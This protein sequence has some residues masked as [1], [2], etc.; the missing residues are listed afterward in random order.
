MSFFYVPLSKN[1]DND[2]ET[3][4]CAGGLEILV[5]KLLLQIL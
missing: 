2:T 3:I 4:L 5:F 1:C